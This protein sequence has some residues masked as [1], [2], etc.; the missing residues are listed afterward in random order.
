MVG[1]LVEKTYLQRGAGDHAHD[2]Q[3]FS[4]TLET[5]NDGNF[6]L[7]AETP[8]TRHLWPLN[9]RLKLSTPDHDKPHRFTYIARFGGYPR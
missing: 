3:A 4:L 1:L 8:C 9:K 5:Q 7:E 6:T 2:V